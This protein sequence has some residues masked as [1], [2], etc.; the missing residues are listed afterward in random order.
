ML[1]RLLK[2]PNQWCSSRL[3]NSNQGSSKI[4]DYAFFD[5]LL[6][7]PDLCTPRH[8]R[9]PTK[10][11]YLECLYVFSLWISDP[12]RFRVI[13]LHSLMPTVNQRE[14]FNRPPNGVRKIIIATNIAE[15]RS[16]GHMFW[17]VGHTYRSVSRNFYVLLLNPALCLKSRWSGQSFSHWYSWQLG[18]PR[19]CRMQSLPDTSTHHWHLKP[20]THYSW[21]QCP[22]LWSHA[23]VFGLNIF[24]FIYMKRDWAEHR[25]YVEALSHTTYVFCIYYIWCKFVTRREIISRLCHILLWPQ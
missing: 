11:I 6:G 2:L 15:T 19:Q 18:G 12:S 17:S 10:E 8:L 24:Y 14:V 1:P 22:V 7:L 13:P 5:C 21:I 25:C 16:V 20:Q 9:P 3:Y 23:S 4:R